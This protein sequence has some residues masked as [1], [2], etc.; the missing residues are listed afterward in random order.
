MS[1]ERRAL[2]SSHA[3][4]EQ[5]RAARYRA[6]VAEHRVAITDLEDDV[7]AQKGKT[8]DEEKE[9]I[10]LL[11]K[12]SAANEKFAQI[13]EENLNMRNEIDI[14][15]QSLQASQEVPLGGRKSCTGKEKCEV[16]EGVMVDEGSN[17][18]GRIRQEMDSKIQILGNKVDYLNAQLRNHNPIHFHKY[19]D[20]C[21]E[22]KL[23]AH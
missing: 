12:L 21:Q 11:Q 17:A 1:K 2:N 9:K 8:R 13:N 15:K 7:V 22:A 18:V 16:G 20:L 3:A 19:R 10:V 5:E 6:A 23:L 4:S 14:L